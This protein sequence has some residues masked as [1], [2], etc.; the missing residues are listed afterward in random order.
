[1]KILS[2]HIF[3][4]YNSKP[5]ILSSA[6]EL[7][8]I[9]I[10]QR[11]II[12]DFLNFH[13][14]LVIGRISQDTSAAVQLEKGICYALANSD[15]IGIAMICDEEYPKRVAV[16]FLFKIHE[17]FKNFIKE[18]KIDLNLYTDDTDIKYK[19]IKDEI[20]EWQNP[21][22][23]DSIMKLQDELNDVVDI[24]RQ[25]LNE[26]L[27]REENLDSLIIKSEELSKTSKSFYIQAKK[28]NKCCNF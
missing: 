21:T 8:F 28:T 2:I 22:K 12:K 19:T 7:S 10:F 9:S 23:K 25:N 16:D 3:S 13:S 14:R 17:D 18:K 15:K 4:L 20:V 6:F 26:L 27:K 11:G 24:M 5:I 1:M